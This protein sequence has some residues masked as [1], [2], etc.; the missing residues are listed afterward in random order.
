M[1]PDDSSIK[2]HLMTAASKICPCHASTAAQSAPHCLHP[3]GPEVLGLSLL[4]E[5]IPQLS[6]TWV[7]QGVKSLHHT[8]VAQWRKHYLYS[9]DKP[10]SRIWHALSLSD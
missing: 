7:P 6:Q 8:S 5:G 9:T 4:V 1:S 2:C 10:S 3:A